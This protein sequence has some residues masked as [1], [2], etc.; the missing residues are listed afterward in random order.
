MA[1]HICQKS[2]VTIHESSYQAEPVAALMVLTQD[3]ST[4]ALPNPLSSFLE[5]SLDTNRDW[6][7]N[8]HGTN[9]R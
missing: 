9:Q 3:I 2:H 8:G 1:I 5:F 6:G 4:L 7:S